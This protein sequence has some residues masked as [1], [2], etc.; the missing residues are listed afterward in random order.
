MSLAWCLW[1]PRKRRRDDE[2]K[3]HSRLG[4]HLD[5]VAVQLD[6]PPADSLV[7]PRAR[8][9]AVKLLRRVDVHG[10]LGAIA[11]KV[12]IGDVVLDYPP[13]Q[14]DHTRPLGANRDCVDLPNV[15]DNVDT[16]LLW[17]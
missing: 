8:I 14:N 13:A 17:R 15:L 1:H 3:H 10:T 6:L 7:R 16:Q 4:V 5:A 11:H 9:A 12:C 2:R